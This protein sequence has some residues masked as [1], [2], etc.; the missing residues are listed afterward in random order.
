[1]VI[2]GGKRTHDSPVRLKIPISFDTKHFGLSLCTIAGKL[3]KMNS[4]FKH[5]I[6]VRE[7][8]SLH[9]K[10]KENCENLSTTVKM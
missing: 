3:N 10:T 2:H 6:T 4:D 1:M 5:D 7:L 8:V 9:A